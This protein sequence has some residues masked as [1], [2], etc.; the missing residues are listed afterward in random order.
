MGPTT[1]ESRHLPYNWSPSSCSCHCCLLSLPDP[2]EASFVTQSKNQSLGDEPGPLWAGCH[3]A[4]LQCSLVFV[5]FAIAI[6]SAFLFL[7]KS[8]RP[9]FS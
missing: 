3:C 4:P 2:L 9:M 8:T 1:P 7:P 6:P 5:V